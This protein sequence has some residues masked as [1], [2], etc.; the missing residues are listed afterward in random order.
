MEKYLKIAL[1]F[2]T[3]F[4]IGS[5]IY[6]VVVFNNEKYA[7]NIVKKPTPTKEEKSNPA[8]ITESGKEFLKIKEAVQSPEENKITNEYDMESITVEGMIYS[9]NVSNWTVELHEKN[10]AENIYTLM[11]TEETAIS[12]LEKNVEFRELRVGDNVIIEGFIKADEKNMVFTDSINI[13][14]SFEFPAA[15]I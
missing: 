7:F 15:A 6:M 14:S 11:L 8:P 13:E 12:R 5:I 2:L 9:I 1:I 4:L 10:N 3:V